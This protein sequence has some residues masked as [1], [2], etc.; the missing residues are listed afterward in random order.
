MYQPPD[1]IWEVN[2]RLRVDEPL[3]GENDPRWVD[4]GAAR[5]EYSH[6]RLYRILGVNSDGAALQL[7]TPPERSYY[8]FC[9]HPGMR[10]EH[11]A[12][13]AFATT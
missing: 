12:S 4:T 7:G 9:G 11:R 8:L 3:D 10:Q 2:R 1:D 5:G 6:H 13:V